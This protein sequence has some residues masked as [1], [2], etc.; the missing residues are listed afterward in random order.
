LAQE[1]RHVDENLL[2]RY[3]LDATDAILKLW[4]ESRGT[5]WRSTMH[6]NVEA[7]TAAPDVFFPTVSLRCLDALLSLIVDFPDWT[8]ADI[9]KAVLEEVV[10]SIITHSHN[11]L[12][13]SLNIE[14]DGEQGLNLFTLSLY[15]QAFSRISSLNALPRD[16]DTAALAKLDAAAKALVGHATFTESDED[17]SL[18]IHPFLLYHSCRAMSSFLALQ[19]TTTPDACRHLVERIKASVRDSIR[20]LIAKQRLAS[21]NPGDS[22]AAAFCAATLAL[23]LTDDDWQYTRASIELCFHAQD[24]NGCWPLGRIVREDKTLVNEKLEISTYEIAAIVA[25]TLGRLADEANERLATG[26]G[27]DSVGRVIQAGRYTERSAVRIAAD[28]PPNV[29]WCTDPAYGEDVIQSWTCATVLQSLLNLARLIEESDRQTILATFAHASPSDADW[30]SWRRWK[31]Y[32]VDGEVDHKHRVVDY[33]HKKLVEPVLASPRRLPNR[34]P[35]SVSVLLFGPPGTS[36]TTIVKAVADGLQWPVVLL[37]PGDFI[38]RGLEYIEAQARSVFERLMTLSRAVVIFDECDELFRDRAPSADTEQTRG[39]TAFVTASMLPKLQELHD[40]GRVIFFICT[41]NFGTIDPAIKRGGRI[42]HIIGIG[43][44]D[45]AA[46]LKIADVTVRELQSGGWTPPAHFDA[47]K[48]RLVV[49]TERFTRSEIQ[50]AVRLLARGK[51]D[52]ESAAES[53]ADGIAKTLTESL[54]ISERDYS[55]FVRFNN[56]FSH[57][58]KQGESS[59]A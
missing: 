43:P 49:K 39:I 50:R 51:W 24:A 2:Q 26:L 38:E 45:E 14:V 3:A 53:Q 32:R 1:A 8:S 7:K 59:H 37:S 48:K 35:S 33:L 12:D 44:P 9:R 6:R 30:P 17:K 58:L 47:A 31:V 55:N 40:R 29:G 15:V 4:D 56:Q 5:F 21:L 42:D 25:E 16:R 11:D 19:R 13:T 46:R 28:A 10:S 54:T 27:A 18:T 23:A 22:V 57:P 20:S 36:K 52:S 41:N 34:N